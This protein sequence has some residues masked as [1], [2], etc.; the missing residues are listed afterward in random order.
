MNNPAFLL[1]SLGSALRQNA[2]QKSGS[3]L[4][5]DTFQ[6]S[7][8][9]ASPQI[10][11]T[12]LCSSHN[13]PHTLELIS[14]SSSEAYEA[15]DRCFR[16]AV[17]RRLMLPHPAARNA[18]DAGQSCSKKSTAGTTAMDVG[19]EVSIAGMLQWPDAQQT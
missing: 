10:L 17:A 8:L 3:P 7:F 1:K 18:A 4:W 14:C 5:K 15:E 13:L 16:V 6:C 2:A 19:M 11:L 9:K 12:V